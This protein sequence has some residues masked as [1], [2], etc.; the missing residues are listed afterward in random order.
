MRA[1]AQ[2][3]AGTGLIYCPQE[4]T[5]HTAAAPG[6][7]GQESGTGSPGE[8]PLTKSARINNCSP[9]LHNLKPLS[10]HPSK[11][12][13]NPTPARPQCDS[14]QKRPTSIRSKQTEAITYQIHPC[15][16]DPAGQTILGH[17]RFR[18]AHSAPQSKPNRCLIYP[19]PP[20]EIFLPL[21][22]LSAC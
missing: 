16:P 1:A 6:R 18:L 22:L 7:C 20:D 14:H 19:V 15:R 17:L 8:I 11:N 13:A 21:C 10:P 12:P 5:E 3:F 2:I 4:P 9:T